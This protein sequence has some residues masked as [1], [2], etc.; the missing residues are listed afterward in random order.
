MHDSYTSMAGEIPDARY[1]SFTLADRAKMRFAVFEPQGELRGTVL[2]LQGR[3][4][5]IEKK[6]LEVGRDLRQRGFRTI[7]FDWR[8]QGLSTRILRDPHRERDHATDFEIFLDDLRQ[9]YRNVVVPRSDGP[10]IVFAHS[11][12]CLLGTRW[13]V[14]SKGEDAPQPNAVIFTA[15]ALAIGVPR[16][17]LPIS[18]MLCRLGFGEYYAM[19]QHNYGGR[20]DTTFLRNVLTHDRSRFTIIEKHFISNPQMAVGGVTWGWLKAALDSIDHLQQPG[21]LERIE[22]PLLALCGGR[23]IVTPP[24][25]AIPLLRRIPHADIYLIRGALHDLMNESDHFRDQAWKYIDS[26]LNSK[27]I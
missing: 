23:D 24:S 27:K 26:F 21:Y 19:G 17:S 6:Y 2:C 20:R 8:G 22:L 15:P 10:L 1:E 14:E 3:R 25:Q 12:G 11:L 16:F 4:E 18:T 13:L 9:F 7:H 5:F